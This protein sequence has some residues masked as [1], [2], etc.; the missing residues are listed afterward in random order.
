MTY[1][2]VATATGVSRPAFSP[3]GK[4]WDWAPRATTKHADLTA[5]IAAAEA[6]APADGLLVQLARYPAP[7]AHTAPLMAQRI[8]HGPWRAD[9]RDL[10]SLTELLD[11]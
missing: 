4:R 3:S 9:G 10:A 6:I 11:A 2:V 5:A 8:G 1:Y 7:D